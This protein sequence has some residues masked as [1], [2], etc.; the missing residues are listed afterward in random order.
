LKKTAKV[1]GL[2]GVGL[3]ALMVLLTI[4]IY[5][6]YNEPLPTGK[7][8]ASADQLADKML[9]A[10][11]YEAYQETNYLSWTFKGAHQ[12][13]WNRSE[14][15]CNVRWDNL[16]VDLDLINKE[17]S[18]VILEGTLYSGPDKN[19]YI[20]TAL[21]YFNNDSFWLVA[22]YKVYDSGVERRLVKTENGDALLVTYISGGTTPGD[23]YL[24]HLDEKGV[25]TSFQMWVKI[26]PIGGISATWE[27]WLTTSSGAKLPGFHKLLFLDLVMSSVQGKK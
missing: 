11:S 6:N 21:S 10:L 23:S 7:Q 20:N 15:K 14:G 16:V 17:K 1:L 26:I 3:F 18:S 27:Q 19:K 2:I 24:W 12:Y 13:Q 8:G 4:L 9:D 25:P 5:I 22:P